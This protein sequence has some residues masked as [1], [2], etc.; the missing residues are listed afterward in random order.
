MDIPTTLLLGLVI[1]LLIFLKW[2]NKPNNLPP[3]PTALPLLGNILSMDNRAPYKT[4]LKV[5]RIF[6]VCLLVFLF[7]F[8]PDF[9][10]FFLHTVIH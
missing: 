2:R 7:F 8:L 6:F 9:Q 5:S 10:I 1:A 3:G 4:F